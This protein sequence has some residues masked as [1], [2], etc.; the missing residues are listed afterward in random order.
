M[1]I[2]EDELEVVTLDLSF[3]R[4][5]SVITSHSASVSAVSKFVATDID[6][7]GNMDLVF[8]DNYLTGKFFIYLGN[9]DN[10][11]DDLFYYT[12][13]YNS[14]FDI[15]DYNVDGK[16]DIVGKSVLLQN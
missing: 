15:F 2:S 4:T 10:T 3:A 6:N 12:V 7:D 13:P 11:F 16:N 14:S 9:G 5:S 8:N 1:N